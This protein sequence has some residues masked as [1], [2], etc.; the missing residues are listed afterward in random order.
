MP[1][2]SEI[3]QQQQQQQQQQLLSSPSASGDCSPGGSSG[4]EV[5]ERRSARWSKAL[6]DVMRVE[7][8]RVEDGQAQLN[9]DDQPLLA[10]RGG[11]QGRRPEAVEP[12][13]PSPP[14]VSLC[15][16]SVASGRGHWAGLERSV[17]VLRRS[18]EEET[19]RR[20]AQTESL[21]VRLQALEQWYDGAEDRKTAIDVAM[22]AQ[23]DGLLACC[24]RLE[25]T[26]NQLATGAADSEELERRHAA[27][28]GSDSVME[29]SQTEQMNAIISAFAVRLDELEQQLALE[30]SG[31]ACR[32]CMDDATPR[33]ATSPRKG[34]HA[35]TTTALIA[36]WESRTPA[37]IV[38]NE[39]T[40]TELTAN[41]EALE[42]ELADVPSRAEDT[43]AVLSARLDALETQLATTALHEVEVA[44]K[45]VSLEMHA[46]DVDTCLRSDV[47]S[48]LEELDSRLDSTEA[49]VAD[50]TRLKGHAS[51][52]QE[53]S[54]MAAH[55][56]TTILEDR[57]T[58]SE[59][60]LGDVRRALAGRRLSTGSSDARLLAEVPAEGDGTYPVANLAKT[61]FDGGLYVDSPVPRS[62]RL[63][64]GVHCAEALAALESIVGSGHSD[65]S[66]NTE[67][68]LANPIPPEVATDEDGASVGA[69]AMLRNN[70][71]SQLRWEAPSPPSMS[72]H[73]IAPA[74]V[75]PNRALLQQVR[76]SPTYEES[77]APFP[78]AKTPNMCRQGPSPSPSVTTLTPPSPIH[79]GGNG[80]ARSK[81]LG[82]PPVPVHGMQSALASVSAPT[83]HVEVAPQAGETGH[84]TGARVAPGGWPSP[85][86]GSGRRTNTTAFARGV[87]RPLHGLIRTEAHKAGG[88]GAGRPHA[89]SISASPLPQEASPWRGLPNS[90][91]A[92]RCQG[93][94]PVPQAE[95]ASALCL[96]PMQATQSMAASPTLA[97]N[98]AVVASPAI[99]AI[100]PATVNT[101][102]EPLPLPPA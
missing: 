89:A 2:P 48:Y 101:G 55:L 3:E 52:F 56:V 64:S 61:S 45:V 65:T 54:L 81:L 67:Y 18:L 96:P 13:A 59:A 76:R 37:H 62:L 41:L 6:Y 85:E 80:L 83:A 24:A 7:A 15:G 28:E 50:W 19:I 44:T 17:D 86:V 35:G 9:N 43:V 8:S 100:A 72:R 20:T 31:K 33:T 91:G 69:R 5:R 93:P 73:E 26:E 74:L 34:D 10:P 71:D 57:A 78:A 46:A 4:D 21:A 92:G 87:R 82:S 38:P 11:R 12:R 94:A 98:E 60:I 102:H 51:S 1:R 32:A 14:L 49:A 47:R 95:S 29:A 75:T 27:S 23:S 99:D 66:D 84:R 70:S 39:D 79:R 97:F 90:N 68:Y 53:Q 88:C 25:Q 16:F 36:A 40:V 42:L 63:R 58:K 30:H 77:P 22:M